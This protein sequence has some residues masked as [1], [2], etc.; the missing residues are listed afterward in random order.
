MLRGK[1]REAKDMR[2]LTQGNWMIHDFESTT[3]LADSVEQS[4]YRAG[5][6]GM[7]YILESA[8]N[9]SQDD[10]PA[11]LD[12]AN[13]VVERLYRNRQIGTSFET[14]WDVEGADVDVAR[15]LS[16]EPE[17]MISTPMS[18][19]AVKPVITLVACAS[20]GN[21]ATIEKVQA[22]GRA[23][24]ALALALEMS[25]HSVEIYSDNVTQ[26]GASNQSV[27][28]TNR[29]VHTVRVLVKAANDVIDPARLMFALTSRDY[30]SVLGDS[31]YPRL[32]D[33]KWNTAYRKYGASAGSP[34]AELYPEGALIMPTVDHYSDAEVTLAAAEKFVLAQL[35]ALGLLAE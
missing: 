18:E 7:E 19:K 3:D 27:T 26:F 14:V 2:I 35:G 10:L 22:R 15:Y 34:C 9:G 23:V 8:R 33:G 30:G 28:A 20:F 25:G 13:A 29:P 16:G 6:P 24:C 4:G 31:F 1:L 5:W 12:I 32:P 21:G 17:C 11:A